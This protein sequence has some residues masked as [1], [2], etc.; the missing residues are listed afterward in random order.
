MESSSSSRHPAASESPLLKVASSAR[1]PTAQNPGVGQTGRSIGSVDSGQ[2]QGSWVF[3]VQSHRFDP[4]T[5]RT[6]V[7]SQY[8]QRAGSREWYSFGTCWTT[9][10]TAGDPYSSGLQSQVSPSLL[11]TNQT[12]ACGPHPVKGWGHKTNTPA[13]QCW[14]SP[15]D[16]IARVRSTIQTNTTYGESVDGWKLRIDRR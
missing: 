11:G 13:K 6:G 9:I 7:E 14:W 15:T 5:A 8:F 10:S 4:T 16:M 3:P 1:R 12:K 2:S